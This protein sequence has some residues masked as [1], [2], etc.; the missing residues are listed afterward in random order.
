MKC[1]TRRYMVCVLLMAQA[2]ADNPPACSRAEVIERVSKL[3]I[4]Q[5]YLPQ[6]STTKPNGPHIPILTPP[7]ETLK[8]RKRIIVVIN[9]T[10]QDLGILA[11]RQLQRELGVNGGSVVNFAKE[12]IK[13]SAVTNDTEKSDIST[14]IFHDGAGAMDDSEIPGLIVMNTGQLLYSHKYKR[15]MTIRSWYALPRKSIAH[16]HIRIHDQENY[17]EGHRTSTEHIKTVFDELLCNPD[18]IATEAEVYV[19]AIEGGVDNVLEVFRTDCKWADF[20]Y[21]RKD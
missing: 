9:D 5:L 2:A 10:V 13:R 18:R 4:R 20:N 15:A 14:S 6:F 17:V 7:L 11:Y 1:A 19:I 12:M 16:D 21:A 3:G 8:A